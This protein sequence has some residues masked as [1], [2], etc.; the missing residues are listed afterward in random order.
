MRP[1]GYAG[2][3]FLTCIPWC[4]GPGDKELAADPTHC[5]LGSLGLPGE[6]VAVSRA[7]RAG[8]CGGPQATLVQL[9]WGKIMLEYSHQCP[10]VESQVQDVPTGVSLQAL[11]GVLARAPEPRPVSS[12]AGMG[13]PVAPR[14][15]CA[16]FLDTVEP[17]IAPSFPPEMR[18]LGVT[19]PHL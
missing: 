12:P 4:T 14:G 8:V 1:V 11:G 2:Q 17:T 13:R 10:R 7:R 5:R 18:C 3:T 16:P 19:E 6:G 9:T 15:P